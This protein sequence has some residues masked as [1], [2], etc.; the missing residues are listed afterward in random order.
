VKFC[1]RTISKNTETGKGNVSEIP[2]IV[3]TVA[4]AISEKMKGYASQAA[5]AASYDFNQRDVSNVINGKPISKNKLKEMAET[6][7][8][9][10]DPLVLRREPNGESDE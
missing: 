10:I 2:E 4:A 8:V 3:E 7:G 1:R 6:L 9:C 5:F